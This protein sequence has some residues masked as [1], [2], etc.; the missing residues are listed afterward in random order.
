MI[1]LENLKQP[2]M[3][4]TCRELRIKNGISVAEFSR[5]ANVTRQAV[6]KFESGKS[7]SIKLFLAYHK[8]GGGDGET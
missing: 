2:I 1:S 6:Y 7:A 8:L 5:M 3:G 4:Q